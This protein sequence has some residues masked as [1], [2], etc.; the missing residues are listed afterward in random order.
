MVLKRT[1]FSVLLAEYAAHC[2]TQSQQC[3]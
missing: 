2:A 3:Y 1:V